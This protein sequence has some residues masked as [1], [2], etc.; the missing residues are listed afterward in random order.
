MAEKFDLNS[1]LFLLTP[2]VEL[3]KA[4]TLV[5]ALVALSWLA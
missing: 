5:S 2:G 3:S 1:L 4:G